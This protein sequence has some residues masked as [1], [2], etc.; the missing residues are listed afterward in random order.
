MKKGLI[1]V[2]ILHFFQLEVSSQEVNLQV[3]FQKVNA[4]SGKISS[5]RY[6]LGES[7]QKVS[8]G[9]DSSNRTSYYDVY[10]KLN[11]ADTLVGYKVASASS[12]GLTQLYNG[13]ELLTL[14]SWDGQLE[15]SPSSKNIRRIK[16]LK[17]SFTQYPFFHNVNTGFQNI[18]K[19]HREKTV[20]LALKTVQ[21]RGNSCFKIT[22]PSGGVQKTN[23]YSNYYIS[24]V[25]FLP[26]GQEIVMET[27][28]SNAR[29]IQTFEYFVSALKANI[30][31]DDD[32]FN[33]ESL[34]GYSRE[35][36]VDESVKPV[37]NEL[38][39]KGSLSPDWELPLINGG[40]LKAGDLKNKVVILDF[41]YKAC[42]PCQRQMIALQQLQD[43]FDKQK[44][45]FIGVNTIDDP[46]KDKL[47]TF[48]KNRGLTMPSVY[49]GREIEKLYQV[50]ASPALFIINQQGIISFSLD[51]YADNLL[52]EVQK[53]VEKLL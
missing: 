13:H 45:V 48:L 25:S 40:T 9:E 24:A 34:P 52:Q 11:P 41:W 4:A 19:Y 51:G 28:I 7:Y 44:V 32:K 14:T 31:I 43:R 29:E 37:S 8:V 20:N 47:Q 21:Y 49:N 18:S 38:L 22:V 1:L 39:K 3:L 6:Q 46:V 2:I 12:S 26:M 10:F 30:K 16:D 33:K 17:H 27:V 15:I 36:I 50:Y 35:S 23:A 53:E 5:G 42:A